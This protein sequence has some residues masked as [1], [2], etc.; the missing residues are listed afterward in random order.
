M[1]YNFFLA[2]EVLTAIHTEKG[3]QVGNTH[4]RPNAGTLENS[5]KLTSAS[6]KSE[7]QGKDKRISV[8]LTTHNAWVSA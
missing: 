6:E 1:K 3:Y 8:H 5:N 7:T 2:G 4:F